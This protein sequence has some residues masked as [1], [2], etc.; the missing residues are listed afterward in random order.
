MPAAQGPSNTGSTTVTQ[1]QFQKL[2]GVALDP[3]ASGDPMARGSCARYKDR[4]LTAYNEVLAMVR[5]GVDAVDEL[6]MVG[7]GGR[8]D[9]GKDRYNAL[10]EPF[11]AMYDEGEVLLQTKLC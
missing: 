4:I 2:F 3:V 6:G 5:E 10:L 8:K 11:E 9:E 7:R 1:E